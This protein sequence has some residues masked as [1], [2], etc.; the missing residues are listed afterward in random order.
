VDGHAFAYRIVVAYLRPRQAALPFQILRPEP[1]AG[2]G[3]DFIPLPQPGV[4]IDYH[5][6]MQPATRP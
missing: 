4:T 2:E 3:K 6:G 5:M 1:D